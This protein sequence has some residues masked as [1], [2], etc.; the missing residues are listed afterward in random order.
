MFTFH[1]SLYYPPNV[2]LGLQELT[3]IPV[4]LPGSHMAWAISLNVCY[5]WAVICKMGLRVFTM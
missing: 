2:S 4:G 3:L 1:V 5:F